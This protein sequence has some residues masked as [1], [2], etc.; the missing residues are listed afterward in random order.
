MDSA[1]SGPIVALDRMVIEQ[2]VQTRLDRAKTLQDE[3]A[4]FI[5]LLDRQDPDPDL[6]AAGDEEDSD[7][8][9]RGDPSWPEWNSLHP[10]MKR[11]PLPPL[12]HEDAEEDD[13]AEEDDPAGQCD[14]DG[15]N[16]NLTAQWATGAGCTIA[17]A[18]EDDDPAGGNVTDEPHDGDEGV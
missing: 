18:P 17:D 4:A 12:P 9:D 7:G 11:G 8:D 10:S 16:T 15:I 3:A 6:E 2:L 13:S 5:A 14:E 1:V